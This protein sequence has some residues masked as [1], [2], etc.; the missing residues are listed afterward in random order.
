MKLARQASPRSSQATT[1]DSSAEHQKVKQDLHSKLGIP[2]NLQRLFFQI[3]SNPEV[4]EDDTAT[5]TQELIEDLSRGLQDRQAILF[6]EGKALGRLV[7]PKIATNT[8]SEADFEGKALP[9][10]TLLVE[11]HY[12]L[13]EPATD[14]GSPRPLQIPA[15]YQFK[16]AKYSIKVF[17][18]ARGSLFPVPEPYLISGSQTAAAV[19]F[20]YQQQQYIRAQQ[21]RWQATDRTSLPP[22]KIS[23]VTVICGSSPHTFFAAFNTATDPASLTSITLS[24]RF[25]LVAACASEHADIASG[26][27]SSV[28]MGIHRTKQSNAILPPAKSSSMLHKAARPSSKIQQQAQSSSASPAKPKSRKSSKKPQPQSPALNTT[29]GLKASES[30]DAALPLLTSQAAEGSVMGDKVLR[31][32]DTNAI[33]NIRE[34]ATGIRR[35]HPQAKSHR[36]ARHQRFEATDSALVLPP[37]EPPVDRINAAADTGPEQRSSPHLQSSGLPN[38]VFSRQHAPSTILQ[39]HQDKDISSHLGAND[40]LTAKRAFT[41]P[42]FAAEGRT[43]EGISYPH[44]AAADRHQHASKSPDA[45]STA[46]NQTTKRSEDL[47]SMAAGPSS[48]PHPCSQQQHGSSS[49]VHGRD[50]EEGLWHLT[51]S[52]RP[53]RQR[54]HQTHSKAKP[55]AGTSAHSLSNRSVMSLQPAEPN[56]HAQAIMDL[57]APALASQEL[58]AAIPSEMPCNGWSIIH[59]GKSY[60]LQADA[61]LKPAW[62]FTAPSGA[63]HAASMQLPRAPHFGSNAVPMHQP[64]YAGHQAFLASAQQQSGSQTFL[65]SSGP[66]QRST[67]P[68]YQQSAPSQDIAPVPVELGIAQLQDWRLDA[69]M[70]RPNIASDR[71]NEKPVPPRSGLRPIQTAPA[72]RETRPSAGPGSPISRHGDLHVPHRRMTIDTGGAARGV[73]SRALQPSYSQ[74][75]AHGSTRGFSGPAAHSTR[76]AHSP[77]LPAQDLHRQS[78]VAHSRFESVASSKQKFEIQ[79]APLQDMTRE[80]QI[81]RYAASQ[82]EGSILRQKSYQGPVRS[83]TSLTHTREASTPEQS[84][85][86]KRASSPEPPLFRPA[87]T[88]AND[89]DAQLLESQTSPSQPHASASSMTCF[90]ADKVMGVQVGSDSAQSGHATACSLA[91][92]TPSSIELPSIMGQLHDPEPCRSSAHL[93]AL[94][95]AS[96]AAYSQGASLASASAAPSAAQPQ[97]DSA[98]ELQSTSRPYAGQ[99]EAQIGP[100]YSSGSSSLGLTHLQQPSEIAIQHVGQAVGPSQQ[101][102]RLGLH[103]TAAALLKPD[104]MPLPVPEE[105]R[106]LSSQQ[107]ASLLH[108]GLHRPN[109]AMALHRSGQNVNLLHELNGAANHPLPTVVGKA[110]V[111]ELALSSASSEA[112]SEGAPSIVQQVPNAGHHLLAMALG[113]ANGQGMSDVLTMSPN[114]GLCGSTLTSAS[115]LG[116][117]SNAGHTQH[118]NF[119]QD[120]T[121]KFQPPSD[122]SSVRD[123]EL[124][125]AADSGDVS[126]GVKSGGGSWDSFAVADMTAG[127][128]IVADD[129]LLAGS[130]GHDFA[131]QAAD[132]GQHGTDRHEGQNLNC[133][134]QPQPIAA[135]T[136]SPTPRSLCQMNPASPQSK[137]AYFKQDVAKEAPD[138]VAA[139][140]EASSV[141]ATDIERFLEQAAPVLQ[142]HTRLRTSDAYEPCLADV[143]RFFQ[144]PSLYGQEIITQGGKRGPARAYY[145]PSLSAMQLFLPT[146]AH[147]GTSAHRPR[148]QIYSHEAE[149]GPGWSSCFRPLAELFEMELPFQRPPLFERIADMAS[150]LL[151]DGLDGQLLLTTRL[152]DLHPASWFAV[153][154]YPI[155][156]I[157]DAPLNGRFLTFHT[158]QPHPL[159]CPAAQLP[160][161]LGLPVAGFCW[162]NLQQENWMA[163]TSK[164]QDASSRESQ[165]TIEDDADA[166]ELEL[167]LEEL[168]ATARCMGQGIGLKHLGPKGFGPIRNL[169]HPDFD[170]FQSR[171]S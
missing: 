151:S 168:Q 162:C 67:R 34:E 153:A 125:R 64:S 25:D 102:Q 92:S 147:D 164:L 99:V 77:K 165:D 45:S 49:Y 112:L 19:S 72:A 166:F 87:M 134:L 95:Q 104:V 94:L 93:R 154:W 103:T 22:A 128:P 140:V 146:E 171:Q 75:L 132:T 40:N 9:G 5:Q 111:Y 152:K 107:P 97:R 120:N 8:C 11:L 157:P 27:D 2:D 116:R 15:D 29:S 170:Y 51:E 126:D 110:D 65:E 139:S 155:Y 136:V 60:E 21:L 35:G 169:R 115:N 54:S 41:G 117:H 84:F 80:Q 137:L 14:R 13:W 43:N 142:P 30:E 24:L 7:H 106:M 55:G 63:L 143:W 76:A 59:Q 46:L 150:G 118:D 47:M 108:A 156:S 50:P 70:Q 31:Q 124:P 12:H 148:H 149:W 79:R 98:T 127:Q 158:L 66:I 62:G 10:A 4:E 123:T 133:E 144:Q 161:R 113:S 33:S 138:P 71:Q 57:P 145:L 88:C 160:S 61:Q 81:R 119:I 23:S 90:N 38:S 82:A 32:Q 20:A 89:H 26:K 83:D 163:A 85:P 135:Q 58:A 74:Q 101:S 36:G 69:E 131:A 141:P 1:L 159:P 68:C 86:D 130:V 42:A 44:D 167:K 17:G 100:H 53:F 122:A 96:L 52:D 109:D 129:Q 37:L 39:E 105:P 28:T 48:K 121:T 18:Q 6:K 16:Q 3:P 91:A 73:A 56:M 78:S 114:P